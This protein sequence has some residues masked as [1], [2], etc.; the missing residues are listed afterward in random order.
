MRR[1]WR[2]RC[3]SSRKRRFA[4]SV[5]FLVTGDEEGPSINGTAKLLAWAAAKGERLDHCIV[6]EPTSL[7][8]LGDTIKHGR[9]GSLTGVSRSTANR[10]TRPIRISLTILCGGCAALDALFSPP[11]DQGDADFAPSNLE[12][13]SVDVGNPASNVIPGEVRLLFNIRFNTIWTPR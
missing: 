6:G 1:L 9:R 12:V 5:S 3:D 2:R 10:D 4:G 7:E 8:K 13:V 11:L